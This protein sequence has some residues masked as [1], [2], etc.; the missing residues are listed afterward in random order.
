MRRPSAIDRE[1]RREKTERARRMKPEDRL[2]A[3]VNISKA[4]GELQRAGQRRREELRK[5]K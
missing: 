2:A 3:S 4:V 5:S 1:K